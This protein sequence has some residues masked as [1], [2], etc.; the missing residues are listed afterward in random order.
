MVKHLVD[1]AEKQAMKQESDQDTQEMIKVNP[2]KRRSKL[3]KSEKV[4]T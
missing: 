4:I 3:S 1:I 2:L